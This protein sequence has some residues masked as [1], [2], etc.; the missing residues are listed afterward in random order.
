MLVSFHVI[1][2]MHFKPSVV[3]KKQARSI[4]P[5]RTWQLSGFIDSPFEKYDQYTEYKVTCY[6]AAFVW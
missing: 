1:I 3:F 2:I 5:V 6:K 4:L